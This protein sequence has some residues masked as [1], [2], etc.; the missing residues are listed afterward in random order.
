MLG[1]SNH[2]RYLKVCTCHA[3]GH[4]PYL[5]CQ[6]DK[7]L[8]KMTV[9]VESTGTRIVVMEWVEVEVKFC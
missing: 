7:H 1:E 8:A 4:H 3:Q 5:A 2:R 9:V 6:E